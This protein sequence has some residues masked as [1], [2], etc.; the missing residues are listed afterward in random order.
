MR[1]KSAVGILIEDQLRNYD[2]VR[3]ASGS[4]AFL[5]RLQKAALEKLVKPHTEIRGVTIAAD[6]LVEALLSNG[7]RFEY[8]LYFPSSVRGNTQDGHRSGEYYSHRTRI[9]YLDEVIRDPNSLG[10]LSGWLNLSP[11]NSRRGGIEQAQKLRTTD[12]SHIFPIVTLLHGLSIHRMLHECFLRP[13]LGRFLPC[14]SLIAT[15]KASTRAIRTILETL[16]EQF[17]RD[18]GTTLQYCGRIDTIPLCVDTAKYRPGNKVALRKELNI[19]QN[20]FVILYL[21]RLSPLKADLL[22]FLTVLKQLCH[23]NPKSELLWIVAGSEEEGYGEALQQAA[24]AMQ[25]RKN[26][27]VQLN[28]SDD[29]KRRLLA[30]SDVFLSLSDSVQ[31]SFGLTP[32][33]AM[34]SGLPQVVSDWSG[35]KDTVCHGVTGFRVPVYWADCDGDLTDTG[36]LLGWEYDHMCLGQSVA[37]DLSKAHEFLQILIDNADL[38]ADM[39]TESR[40]R[41]ESLYGFTPVTQQ[42][43]TLW[44]ELSRIAKAS[45]SNHLDVEYDKPRYCKFFGHFPTALI[46]DETRVAITDLGRQTARD[47][48]GSSLV[49][50]TRFPQE[51]LDEQILWSLLLQMERNSQDSALM[52]QEQTTGSSKSLSELIASACQSGKYHP[53]H[54]R[55]HILWLLKYGYA[56]VSSSVLESYMLNEAS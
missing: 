38:R 14:D 7:E 12:S 21:G 4:A 51:I 47:K 26:L 48:Q 18:F 13:L 23:D 25:I 56:R 2:A 34:A 54:V 46:T 24:S 41:A 39:A 55:R 28:I 42:Y 29:I 45:Q 32:I 27:K 19:K 40:K 33:E 10:H 11:F 31:E 44:D 5:E 37:V 1:D 8:E 15:S 6:T 50:G 35:Y 22:P 20:T 52:L 16:S 17:N 36:S 49:M 53:A 30:A 9:T 3:N 43:E